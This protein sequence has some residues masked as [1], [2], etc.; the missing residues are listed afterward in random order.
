[1]RP[2]INLKMIA[3]SRIWINLR[4]KEALAKLVFEVGYYDSSYWNVSAYE[5]E[6]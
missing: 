4:Q 3:E 5:S 1:M 6:R 2:N